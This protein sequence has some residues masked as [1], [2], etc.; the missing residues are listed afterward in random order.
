MDFFS[1]AFQMKLVDG[2][3]Y[4]ASHDGPYLIHCIEGKDRTGFVCMLA[5]AL[6]G[7][8][9]DEI[10]EDYM[11]TYANYYGITKESDEAKYNIIVAEVLDPMIKTVIDEP[12]VDYKTVDYSWYAERFLVTA[13]MN[14]E[15]VAKV[16][17]VLCSDEETAADG[18][19]E[20]DAAAEP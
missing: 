7:A 19:E 9:Y 20:S 16:K 13:G 17:S 10:V 4:M 3:R 6:C 8:S 11:T 2:F 12:G 15:N 14:E 5:E 18:A 1:E